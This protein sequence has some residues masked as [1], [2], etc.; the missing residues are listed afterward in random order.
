MRKSIFTIVLLFSSL[1]YTTAGRAAITPSA[2]GTSVIQAVLE[3][4]ATYKL[5]DLQKLAGRKFTFKEKVSFWLLKGKIKNSGTN[6]FSKSLAGKILNKSVAR[7]HK[8]ANPAEAGSLGQTAFIF[9][10]I[11]AGL[12]VAG[13]FLPYII[14]GSLVSAIL[15]IVLGTLG[16]KKDP[17]DAKA[18]VGKLLGWI[19]LGLIV[20]LFAI[21]IL[22]FA[23][24]FD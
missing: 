12:L 18:K 13:L 21:V 16:S 5:K 23:S 20:I 7:K 17:S 9:G 6:G 11:A 3:K 1:F 8:S 15:A 19:T 4:I 10:L 2:D 24:I 22:A 14:I